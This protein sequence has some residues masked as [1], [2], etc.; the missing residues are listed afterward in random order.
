MIITGGLHVS[1]RYDGEVSG[2][3]QRVF[4]YG[5][6]GFSVFDANTM[7]RDY[8]S[9]DEIEKY[10]RLF[11]PQVF[12]GDCTNSGLAPFQE[13]DFRSVNTVCMSLSRP[14]KT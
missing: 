4:T 9:G 2:R 14:I 13:R 1:Q 10:T 11:Q 6:R 3:I 5:G 12:N 8:E 7:V